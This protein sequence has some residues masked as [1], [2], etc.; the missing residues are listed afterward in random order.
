MFC[1][2]PRL[3]F[4]DEPKL[5]FIDCKPSQTKFVENTI[6]QLGCDRG[7]V[8]GAKYVKCE[9]NQLDAATAHWVTDNAE[10]PSCL[11]ESKEKT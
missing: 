5:D 9:R 4:K 3:T 8:V 10:K 2:H 7:S 1:P 11:S 6:C